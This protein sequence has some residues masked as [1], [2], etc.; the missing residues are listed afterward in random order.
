MPQ[1]LIGGIREHFHKAQINFD[2]FHIIKIINEAVDEVRRVEQRDR[3]ELSKSRHVWL[4]NPENL[5]TSQAERL[6]EL[7]L[8]KL[9]LKT[10]RAYHLKL[11]FQELFTQPVEQ[12][13]AFLKKWY[14]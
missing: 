6:K 11:N 10:T 8:P 4:K 3:P 5:K 14:F 2:K 1:A 9:N 7:S 12:S 13:E